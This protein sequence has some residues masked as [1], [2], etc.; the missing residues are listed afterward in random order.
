MHEFSQGNNS[1]ADSQNESEAL[2][3]LS[4]SRPYLEVMVRKGRA[5]VF[6]LI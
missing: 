2:L 5:T 4:K 1:I 3:L 6:F